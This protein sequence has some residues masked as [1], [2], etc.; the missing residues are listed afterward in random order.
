[1]TKSLD[2]ITKQ[3]TMK[4]LKVIEE[5]ED[6]KLL[7]NEK[8]MNCEFNIAGSLALTLTNSISV[9]TNI[10]HYRLVNKF[11]DYIVKEINRRMHH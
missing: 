3:I 10:P 7:D 2:E 9:A 6:I 5:D 8:Y 11:C 1:M 4:M